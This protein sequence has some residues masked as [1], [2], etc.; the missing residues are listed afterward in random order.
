[1][2]EQDYPK[3]PTVNVTTNHKI[4]KKLHFN[5]ELDKTN[6][7]KLLK[8]TGK[9]FQMH[10]FPILVD[11]N[12]SVIDG[13]HRLEVCRQLKTPIY[14]IV[15]GESNSSCNAVRSVNVAGKAH[16]LG[17][18][19]QMAIKNNNK[20]ALIV[21]SIFLEFKGFF[22]ITLIARLLNTFH[23]GG[24]TS[25]KFD[26]GTYKINY[27]SETRELLASIVKATSME[28]GKKERVV[29]ALATV[30]QKSKTGIA[31]TVGRIDKNWFKFVITGRRKELIRQM[32]DAYNYKLTESN[33]IK[34]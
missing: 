6:L 27:L 17:D 5:R 12:Y 23:S 19:I 14:F 8:E 11:S 25:A 4:F 16:N 34:I 26:D 18:K 9:E 1:M 7:N 33:R 13:Q 2:T 22:K 29:T 21:E 31:N 20:E 10:K 30:T 15:D 32:I 24:G 3:A 28:D